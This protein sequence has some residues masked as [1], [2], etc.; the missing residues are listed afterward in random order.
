M[1]VFISYRRADN[2][3][4]AHAVHQL[5][6]SQGLDTFLDVESLTAGVQFPE[7]IRTR[8]LNS[9][10]LIALIGPAWD[11]GRLGHEEDFVRQELAIAHQHDLRVIPVLHSGAPPP[12]TLHLPPALAWLTHRNMFCLGEA[13]HLERDIERLAEQI[14]AQVPVLADLQALAWRQYEH[15]DHVGL[16]ETAKKAWQEHAD[17]PSPALADCCR[18]AALSYTRLGVISG[19]RDLW[20]ARALSTAFLAD[21]PHAFAASM[22]PFFFRLLH[23]G[24]LGEAREILQEISRLIQTNDPSQLPPVRMMRRLVTEKSAYLHYLEGDHSAALRGY[25]DALGYT[26]PEADLRGG[27]KVAGAIALCHASLGEVARARDELDGVLVAAERNGFADVAETA[28]ANRSALDA[29]G[30]LRPFEVV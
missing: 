20:Q 17:R 16:I 2:A 13:K 15:S 22:L 9:N 29:G 26:S 28:R 5:L 19:P 30:P 14:K 10:V 25:K 8:L 27:L 4:L 18:V 23:D 1:K 3:Y 7:A 6:S 11:A 21:A 12:D 24:L